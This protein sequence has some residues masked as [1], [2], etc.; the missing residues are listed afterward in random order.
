MTAPHLDL[1]HKTERPWP[2]PRLK[3][4][5]IIGHTTATTSRV[6][7]RTGQEGEFQLLHF[8]EDD[9]SAKEWFQN[10]KNMAPF[11]IGEAPQGVEVS[12]PFQ[13]TW[14][15]D[16]T[17]VVDLDKL[18]PGKK[19]CYALYGTKGERLILGHDKGHAFRTPS[20][21]TGEF[22][23]GLFSCHM[24]FKR[25]GLFFKKTEVVNMDVWDIMCHALRR[26]CDSKGDLDFVIAGGDQCYTDGIPTL[27]IWR[28]LNDNMMGKDKNGE[29]TPSVDTM[30]NMYRDIYRGYW[31][32]YPVRRVFSSIPTYM[33]W[34]DH[35][36]GDGWGSHEL[37]GEEMNEVLPDLEAR[38]LTKSDGMELI[39]RM[40][41]A[42]KRVYREYQHS[43]NPSTPDGQFDYDFH[44]KGC[45]FY[46]L[47]G[48]G[49]RDIERPSFRIL[50]EEQF[51]R[52]ESHVNALDPEKVKHLFVVSA[53]PVLH[54]Y[55]QLVEQADSLVMDVGN[56]T[57]DLRDAW[58]HPLH[59]EERKSLMRVLFQAAARGIKVA[60]LSGD[61]HVSAAF[62]ISDGEGNSIFQLTSSAVT[63]NL[64]MI[65]S[66]VL[67]LAVP[68]DGETK[69]GY[70]FERLALRTDP[71]YS[72]IRV[73]PD[74]GKAVFQIYGKQTVQ[75]PNRMR[76]EEKVAQTSRKGRFRDAEQ[77][78]FPVGHSLA[79]IYLS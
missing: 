11:P 63:Y 79:K 35:E 76:A 40:G 32:F 20:D 75:R 24:P 9:S 21:G 5:A 68:D 58:E 51:R 31:G 26:R 30:I 18:T 16:A 41:T 28:H 73:N 64:G 13:T 43:H 10:N 61:V 70:T 7:V 27:D 1:I 67:R 4:A 15:T 33:I 71:S 44:H 34:D 54:M 52:F 60:I 47:D 23:F 78:E 2:N 8:R 3:I 36:L 38:G 74:N 53:V 25:S 29:L 14:D 45:E 22:R 17:H 55:D 56:L 65:Q 19:F 69:D 6:W 77:E 72:A 66:W 42:A 37:N 62:K 49:H 59:N 46:V 57:D 48:R 50:G 12:P 39:R